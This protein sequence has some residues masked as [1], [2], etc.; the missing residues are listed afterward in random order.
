M[1]ILILF[2]VFVAGVLLG[3]YLH[4]EFLKHMMKKGYVMFDFT[5]KFRKEFLKEDDLMRKI[6]KSNIVYIDG[7]TVKDRYR[8]PELQFFISPITIEM[9]EKL[10]VIESWNDDLK[11]LKLVKK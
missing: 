2:V 9:L 8:E 5:N 4:K 10:Y 7:K 1:N 3:G 11:I 6:T